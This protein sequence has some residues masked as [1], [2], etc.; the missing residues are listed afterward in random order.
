MVRFYLIVGLQLK[1]FNFFGHTVA[2]LHQRSAVRDNMRKFFLITALAIPLI[3]VGSADTSATGS[4]RGIGVCLGGFCIGQTINARRFGREHWIVPVNNPRSGI[5][6]HYVPC[7]N[8]TCKPTVAFRGYPPQVQKDL[9][10]ALSWQFSD[11]SSH[12]YT[13]ITNKNLPILRRYRYEC[14]ASSP[15]D[16]FV[17]RALS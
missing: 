16:E 4:D 13:T 10:S 7:T 14:V 5:S 12:S 6:Y 1:S 11:G 15:R 2:K 8:S 3:T 17:A 9:A